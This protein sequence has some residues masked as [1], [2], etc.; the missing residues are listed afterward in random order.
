MRQK[1][2]TQKEY[3]SALGI[4]EK[5]SFYKL[6][7]YYGAGNTGTNN[8]GI[9]T[10]TNSGA[11]NSESGNVGTNTSEAGNTSETGNVE[12][13]QA[14]ISADSMAMDETTMAAALDRWLADAPDEEILLKVYDE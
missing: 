8:A 7:M 12:T 4:S 3:L 10:E 14:G 9:N 13:S 5:A 1:Q 11:D 6:M 2:T